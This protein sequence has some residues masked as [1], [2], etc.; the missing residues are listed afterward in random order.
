MVETAR[1]RRLTS[2]S[3]GV[4][5]THEAGALEEL[6]S[7]V[8]SGSSLF[9]F[10]LYFIVRDRDP[11]ALNARSNILKSLLKGYEVDVDAPPIQ[12]E[13]YNL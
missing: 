5:E 10:Y 3:Q 7:R 9:E 13:L 4:T 8:L 6:A 1:R 12:R 2:G 11:K